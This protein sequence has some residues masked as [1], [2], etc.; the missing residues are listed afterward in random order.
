[1]YVSKKVERAKKHINN[2]VGKAAAWW[3]KLMLKPK[4]NKR[5]GTNQE[6]EKQVTVIY[7]YITYKTKLYDS[8]AAI[9]VS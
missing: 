2:G 4:L 3:E 6:R 7:I 9:T 5:R 1:M 8:N